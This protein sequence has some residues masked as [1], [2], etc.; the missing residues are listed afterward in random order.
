VAP[1]QGRNAPGDPIP[2]MGQLTDT[3]DAKK[4]IFNRY[5]LIAPQ[6]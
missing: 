6:P 4:K 2:E 3:V 1:L 5:A